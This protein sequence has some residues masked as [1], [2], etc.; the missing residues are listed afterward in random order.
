MELNPCRYPSVLMDNDG[1]RSYRY[2]PCDFLTL[3][4]PQVYTYPPTQAVNLKPAFEITHHNLLKLDVCNS[5]LTNAATEKEYLLFPAN[6]IR[7][8]ATSNSYQ[9]SNLST[10]H[11]NSPLILSLD[12]PV[13]S[14]T[15]LVAI[16][17][18]HSNQVSIQM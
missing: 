1:T 13:T 16:C 17:S 2:Q 11:L 4:N 5:Y 15:K 6:E 10:V 9:C 7:N 3:T 18:F 14:C 12:K 8:Q